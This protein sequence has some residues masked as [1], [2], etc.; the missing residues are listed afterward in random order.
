MPVFDS[1]QRASFDGYEFPVRS[2]EIKG[3]YRHHVHEYLRVPGG[4]IEKLERG[5]YV[6]E[7]DVPM[8]ATIRGYGGLWPTGVDVLRKKFEEGIT[9]QLVVPT[10]GS[11]P[12]MLTDWTQTA[13]MGRVRSGENLRLPFLEDQTQLFITNALAEVRQSSLQ[14]SGDKL[15]LTLEDFA[16]PPDERSVFDQITG[17]AN[18]ILAIKDQSDLYGGLLAAKV[19]QLTN[20]INQADRQ[21]QSLQDPVNH[22][23]LDAL[24]E[25]W[26][27]TITLGKNLAESPQGPRL[28]IVPKVMPVTEIAKATQDLGGDD[29][30]ARIILNNDLEDAFA[31][32]AGKQIIYFAA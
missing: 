8:H 2:V 22:E 17:L 30:A 24:H 20:L 32:A 23:L 25:L 18:S 1:L 12:A 21:L 16:L 14:S 31:V 5:L 9:S 27:S 28:Y 19:A 6:I 26:D 7:M 4:V 29:D 15:A 10:I 13:E 3:R 11:I